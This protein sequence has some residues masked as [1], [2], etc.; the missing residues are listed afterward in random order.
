MW[1]AGRL[2]LGDMIEKNMEKS[3]LEKILFKSVHPNTVELQKQETA[4]I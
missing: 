4:N 1:R 3:Q 2:N